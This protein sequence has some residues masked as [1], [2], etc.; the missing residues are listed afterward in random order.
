MEKVR[1]LIA[2]GN[3]E[4]RTQ[5]TQILRRQGINV[6]GEAADGQDALLKITRLKPGVVISDMHL[7]KIDGVGLIREAKMQLGDGYP[8]FIMIS[9]FD[10]SIFGLKTSSLSIS[11]SLKFSR[12]DFAFLR[13]SL[14]DIENTMSPYLISLGM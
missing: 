13:I 14:V 1:V 9:S 11:H 2:E 12:I 6:I 7:G 5:C 3:D 8:A 4:L 10:R